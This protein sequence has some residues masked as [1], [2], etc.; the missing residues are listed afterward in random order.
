MS[1]RLDTDTH[2]RSVQGIGCHEGH[3]TGPPCHYCQWVIGQVS[4]ACGS[5]EAAGEI[6][7]DSGLE[8]STW[9][10]KPTWGIFVTF[11]PINLEFVAIFWASETS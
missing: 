10:G 6:P 7:S 8:I 3:I 5:P 1:C 11:S 4:G 9:Q 2:E